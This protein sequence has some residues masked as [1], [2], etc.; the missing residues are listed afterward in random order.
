MALRNVA[1]EGMEPLFNLLRDGAVALANFLVS[2]QVQQFGADVKATMQDIVDSMA[3]VKDAVSRV[4][5]AFKTAGAGGAFS[6]LLTEVQS[7]AQQ[8]FGAGVNVVSE[9]AGGLLSGAGNLIVE[10]ANFIADTIASYLI[11]QSPPP[12]GPLSEIANGGTALIEAYVDGMKQGLGGIG[13]IAVQVKDALGNVEIAMTLEQGRSALLAAGTNMQA[14]EA[15]ANDVEGALRTI[16][17]ALQTNQSTLHDYQNAVTDIKDAYDAAIEPLQRQVDALKE[18]NDLAQKQADIQSRIALAQLKGALQNAQ[19]DPVKR[20]Q[21]QTQ[22]DILDQQEKELSLQERSVA[23]SKQASDITSKTQVDELRAQALKA[24]QAGDAEKAKKLTEQA[25]AASL[26]NNTHSTEAN[27]LAQRRLALQQQQNQ[28]QQQLNGMVD[29]EAVA[30]IKTQQAQVHAVKDARDI[31]NEVADL[32]RELQAAP[33]IAQIKDLQAQQ[34]ALVKPIEERIKQTQREG[35]ALQEQ[36]KQ[37][38]G[39]KSDINDVLQAQRALAAEAKKAEADAKKASKDAIGNDKVDVGAIFGT[40][41]IDE[42]ATLIGKSFATKISEWFKTNGV[43]IVSTGIGAML[44]GALF[45]PLGAI[46]GG[47]FGQAFVKRMEEN[48]GSM[49]N[50]GGL[51]AGKISD[52]LN[53]DTG[54]ATNAAEA[55]G[56]IWETVKGRIQTAIDDIIQKIADLTGTDVSGATTNIEKL[57]A[58]WDTVKTKTT[59]A[60][61]DIK[62]AITPLATEITR[63]WQSVVDTFNSAEFKDNVSTIVKNMSLVFGALKTDADNTKIALEGVSNFTIGGAIQ[64]ATHDLALLSTAF[65]N[66]LDTIATV[67]R[68]YAMWLQTFSDVGKQIILI[69]KSISQAIAGDWEGAQATYN[70]RLSID[71]QIKERGEL[72]DKEMT[73]LLARIKARTA[74]ANAAGQAVV[75][76]IATGMDQAAPTVEEASANL[77]TQSVTSKFA[78]TMRSQSPSVVMIEQGTFIGLGLTQ[79][80][81]ESTPTVIAAVTDQTAQML[82]AY[83]EGWSAIHAGTTTQLDEMYALIQGKL[84]DMVGLV[85]IT[86]GA[87]QAAFATGFSAIHTQTGTQLGE[88]Y[89]LIMMQ[90]EKWH[91]AGLA[92]GN[93]LAEGI[94]S[95][96]LNVQRSGMQMMS[97]VTGGSKASPQLQQILNEM[98]AK[99]KLDAK[100]FTAQMQHESAGFDP[101]VISG[102]R[103]GGSG[104][105]GIGQFMPATLTAMLKKNGLTLD[106]YLGNAKVQVEL[107]AQHM[108]ELVQVFG[109][110]DK[111][112]MAYNGGA[113]GAGSSATVKY[114]DI[115]HQVA[116]TLQAQNTGGGTQLMSAVAGRMNLNVDQI[117]AGRQAGLSMAEAQAICGPYAAVLFAQATGKT[118]SLAEA[119]EL[120]SA[121]GWTAARGMGGT[122]NFMALLGRMGIQAVRQ[123]ATPENVN[124]ALAAGNPIALSTQRHYFVGQGGTAE[125]GINVGATGTVMSRY[126]GTANMTLAQINDVGD[127]ISDLIVLTQKLDTQGQQTFG[128]LTKVTGQFGDVLGAGVADAD[129]AITENGQ[130]SEAAAASMTASTQTLTQSIQQGIVPAG[131]A[132]RDAVGQMAIGIQPL[133]ATWAAGGM[134]SAQLAESIVQLSSQ[135]GLATQPLASFAAGNVSVGEALRQV[136]GALATADPAF[137]A[138]QEQFLGSQL[139]VEQLADVLLSGLANVTGTVG[140]ALQQIASSTVPLQTA[141]ATGAISGEQFAQSV[142]QLAATSGLTQAPLRQMQDGVITTGEALG[143]VVA[144][145]AETNPELAELAKNIQSGNVPLEEGAK[146]FLDWSKAQADAQTATTE[147][148][149]V[150]QD[151]PAA[152]T[153][154]QAP[155]ESAA[156]DTMQA[157]P[158]ATTEALDASVSAI[159]NIKGPASSAAAEVGT[160]IVESMRSAIM[161]AADSL[162]EAAQSVV[163]KALD[164]AKKAAEKVKESVGKGGGGDDHEEKASGGRLTPGVWTLVGEQG[165]ELI[166]PSGYV[167]NARDTTSMLL[168]G[169]NSGLF[170]LQKYASGGKLSSSKKS[171]SKKKGKDKGG[172]SSSDTPATPQHV[173]APKTREELDL[174]GRILQYEKQR[175][176]HLANMVGLEEEIRLEKRAQEDAV[177]GSLQRQLAVNA[178]ELSILQIDHKILDMNVRDTVESKSMLSLNKEMR[179]VKDAQTD[180]AKGTLEVQLE[181]NKLSI[182]QL[183]G[184]RDIAQLQNDS[185]SVRQEAATVEKQIQDIQK[186]SVED[187][188]AIQAIQAVQHKNQLESNQLQIASAGLQAEIAATEQEINTTLAGTAQQRAVMAANAQRMAEIDL[189]TLQVQAQ[190]LPIQTQ[191]RNIQEAIDDAQRGSLDTQYAAIDAQTESAKL[192]LEEISI[193]GKLRDINAGT[194]E[195]SQQEINDL[196]KRLEIINNQKAQIQD[197]AEIQQLQAT[198]N[199]AAQQKQLVALQ[200]QERTHNDV[201]STL[202]DEKSAVQNTTDQINAQNQVSVAGQQAKLTELNTQMTVY[203]AQVANLQAQNAVMD[204][205]VQNIQLGNTIRA[206]ALGAQLINLQ[207]QVEKYDQQILR[208]QMQN[209]KYAAQ[210]T[211]INSN[212]A[213][214]AAGF[215]AQIIALD[216]TLTMRQRDIDKLKD[217]KDYLQGQNDLIQIQND[218]SGKMHDANLIRLQAQ[219]TE[220]DH[221]LDDINAQLGSLNAQKAVYE[222]IRNLAD[223]IANRPANPPPAGGGS[224]TGGP[225]GNVVATAT[226][227]GAQTLYLSRGTGTDGWYTSSGQMVVQG[228]TANPPSGYNVR[229]MAKGGTWH[230]GEVAVLGE[231]G[232]EIAI[233]KQDMHVFPHEKSEAIA[234]AFGRGT[235]SVGKTDVVGKAVTVNVEYHRHSG[236]DYGEGTLSQVV[237]EAVNV[238]LRS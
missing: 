116:D 103:K 207:A 227:S 92:L 14:L 230:A 85:P 180:A 61:D 189:Q 156:T 25:Q 143:Q 57:G 173:S 195:M 63:Q 162:A 232:P 112:L 31:N 70:E 11:G 215:N 73:D 47:I 193:N 108:S 158:Q 93:A 23:L 197:T 105:L 4:W 159:R 19:G 91:A 13:D 101:N 28:I 95:A 89:A 111:A 41:K 40:Q 174:E 102:A 190:L 213:L 133:I 3:P 183:T 87:M 71:Q 106:Q 114:K 151:L 187:Q 194:L 236:T 22:L 6:Q 203:E 163:Q 54:K 123:Q 56:I 175:A 167:Y 231:D 79:G 209:D 129:Q 161:D 212:N 45:G 110:Y 217:E 169:I 74:E 226:K 170:T 139:S 138:I 107:A 152:L 90:S 119:K 210:T 140:P 16:D 185:L 82:A 206:D 81:T 145:V 68:R 165:A 204:L 21:L 164:A 233:A 64:S 83:T 147:S 205:Q 182:A 214:A 42:A 26:A 78:Q 80:I 10:A 75:Q 150:I 84:T 225:P 192:R 12:V 154:I 46:A 44:G 24:K 8:M 135:T 29:K 69:A 229:W 49:E 113:G 104:E 136:L 148:S 155:M 117:T 120:A 144:Q 34:Q 99:Y 88:I 17:D 35:E 7:L 179:L 27:Q 76:G 130:K 228:G 127:G 177:K 36:R 188:I 134:T 67:D 15:T 234:R 55:F 94:A 65:V 201:L 39:L 198:V 48:F 37:W 153:D 172:D 237:R 32:Q 52:A 60:I 220:Q 166:S 20:A 223:Q 97:S 58:I 157:L 142:V 176:D 149:Q 2:P 33:L 126:G 196:Q 128:N 235:R 181:L 238:A 222:A 146:M 184:E 53:I 224:S 178:N 18:T 62:A 96:Q 115:V 1:A 5:E 211:L 86:M 121:V 51:I 59:T 38:Q 66:L 118:P 124:A 132:A 137:A 219:K 109:D 122:G 125:G 98:A 208:I 100:L 191:M 199:T 200:A 216:A 168:S 77:A 43:T 72:A 186:G 160:A 131:L 50:L 30:R 9:F 171:K 218:I 221:I 141:F 202:G